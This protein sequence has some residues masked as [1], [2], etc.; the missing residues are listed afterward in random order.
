MKKII[1]Y[2]SLVVLATAMLSA[3]T[4][5]ANI[6]TPYDEGPAVV[7]A[8]ELSAFFGT[9]S[10]APL[11]GTIWVTADESEFNR[12]IYF[13]DGRIYLY[14][15]EIE[16]GVMCRWSELYSAPY[17]LFNGKI[18]TCLS[19][20]S[21]GKTINTERLEIIRGDNNYT[22]TADGIPFTYVGDYATYAEDL[23]YQW[24]YIYANITRL[25]PWED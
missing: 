24:M 6:V 17:T 2:I 18:L 19:Y 16:D 5:P 7:S 9:R 22:F 25:I 4:K 11:E 14:Y 21:Y 20:P 15:G 1:T 8:S 23:Q 3:C 12:Y 13:D 10:N